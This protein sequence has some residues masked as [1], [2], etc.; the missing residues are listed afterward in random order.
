MWII[1]PR[2]RSAK[3][4]KGVAGGEMLDY[5]NRITSFNMCDTIVNNNTKLT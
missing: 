3:A 4:K 5:I 1:R 2:I